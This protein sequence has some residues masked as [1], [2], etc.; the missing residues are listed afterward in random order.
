M[1]AYQYQA[2][3]MLIIT[4]QGYGAVCWYSASVFLL[5]ALKE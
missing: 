4:D 1:S 2:N 5:N 3:V